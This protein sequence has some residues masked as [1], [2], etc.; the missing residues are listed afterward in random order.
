MA[1]LAIARRWRPHKFEDLVGQG[2]VVQTLKNAILTERVSH[3]Y[4]FCGA[5]GVGKTSVARIFSK[6]LR[7]PNAKDAVPCNTC[8]E[9]VAISESRSVDVAEIDGASHNGVEAVRSIRDNVG[10]S[11]SSGFYKIYIID[12]AH[13]LSLSAF[14]A[15]LK[16]LEEPPPHVIFVLATTEPQKIP[17]TIL[18]RCQRFEFRRL[19]QTQIVTR[20]KEILVTEKVQ[21][22]EGALLTLASHADGSLR[23][24]LSLLDQVLSHQSQS[25]GELQEAEVVTALGISP[26]SSLTE[27]WAAVID[28]DIAA[29]LKLV[30]AAHGAGVDLKHFGERCLEELRLLYLIALSRESKAEVTA[31]GLDIAAAHYTALEK[32]AAKTNRIALERM[33]Q[34]L[35][36]AASQLS[37]ASYPRFV[38]EM[39]AVR[40]AQLE[41]LA[42]LER[43]ATQTPVQTAPAPRHEPRPTPA[44][45]APAPRPAATAPPAPKPGL[46]TAPPPSA[47][48]PPPPTQR[49]PEPPPPGEAAPMRRASLDSGDEPNWQ[50]FIDAV[51]KKRPLLGALLCH[52]EFRLG[53][54]K[55]IMLT[56]PENS[57]YE[58][59]AKDTKNRS[60][61]EEQIKAYFG[62]NASLAVGAGKGSDLRSLENNRQEEA[63]R[64]RKDAVEHPSVVQMRETLGA[65]IID[66]NVEV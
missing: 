26:A 40:M 61:I 22:S 47:P 21:L 65:E 5:R 66:V 51:M 41:P 32:L 48:R 58:R 2:H 17:V 11:A 53:A 7:C 19:S 60:D 52:G 28:K 46:S 27:F 1:Y 29:V 9:C 20:V 31:E 24:A 39:T 59:Q 8:P 13:M 64:L 10:Y 34:I 56:F 25:G 57:F 38:L 55:Q 4:L 33:A 45:A 16:T 42:Q 3:A 63:A 18:S 14:N 50:G 6:A 15:L 23:D 49:P 43:A 30:A 62:P 54:G 44:P 35:N 37:W 12:E 36:Q